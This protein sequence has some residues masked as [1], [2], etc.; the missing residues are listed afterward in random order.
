MNCRCLAR[1]PI[2]R[3][4]FAK[5][6][7]VSVSRKNTSNWL[8]IRALTLTLAPL[9]IIL[10]LAFC[11]TQKPGGMLKP[12]PSL[13]AALWPIRHFVLDRARTGS[14]EG[15]PETLGSVAR[16]GPHV[17]VTVRDTGPGLKPEVL[18]RLFEAF[19]T[20]KPQG[21]GMGLAI[22]QSIIQAHGGGSGPRSV[23][24]KVPSFRSFYRSVRRGRSSS[25]KRALM[26]TST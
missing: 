14:A 18:E 26:T 10:G 7:P 4:K 19:Y 16:A 20:T 11:Q 2:L 21:L 22:S 13:T 24:L 15:I 8:K 12:E 25:R 17:L 9:V 23:R 5:E 1:R 6:K 3:E